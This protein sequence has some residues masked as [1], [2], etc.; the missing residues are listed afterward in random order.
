MRITG[1][2][3]FLLPPVIYT[4]M[5]TWGTLA[6]AICARRKATRSCGHSKI[7]G[8]PLPSRRRAGVQQRPHRKWL[9]AYGA[10][11]GR[12]LLEPGFF[13]CDCGLPSFRFRGLITSFLRYFP[14]TSRES[15]LSPPCYQHHCGSVACQLQISRRADANGASPPTFPSSFRSLPSLLFYLSLFRLVRVCVVRASSPARACARCS[16]VRLAAR[17]LFVPCSS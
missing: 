16:A 5:C 9:P 2:F 1:S 13:A 15:W 6:A 8:S 17:A 3:H 7:A 11:I 14:F 10:E 12:E 4:Y